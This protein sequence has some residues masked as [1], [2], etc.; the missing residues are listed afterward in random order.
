MKLLACFNRILLSVCL[1]FVSHANADDAQRGAPRVSY[2]DASHSTLLLDVA[3]KQYVVDV[4]AGSIRDA[5]TTASQTSAS[6]APSPGPSPAA[7]LFQQ[8]CASC[9][10]TDG[11]GTR[12]A[13]TPDFTSHS[14]QNGLSDQQIVSTIRNGKPGRMPAWSGKLSDAQITE[15][16]A[17]IR[18]FANAAPGSSSTAQQEAA[19]SGVY[20]PGDDLLVSLPTGRAVERH[21]LYVN[22]THRF[23]D[24][25]FTGPGKGAELLGLDSV[26]ISSFGLRYGVTDKL[27]VSVWRSPS[28]IER[29]IQIM[30]AYNLLDENHEA[31]LNVSVRFSVEGQ[32]NFQRSFTENIEAIFSRTILS[33]A[34]F[35]V[36]PTFSFNARRLEP[37]GLVSSQIP[38]FPGVNTFSIGFGGALDIRPTVALVAEIIPTLFNSGELGI[39]RPAYSFGIQK[40]LW[41]HAFT[42]ALTNSPGTTVSQRAGTRATY[43]GMPNADTPAGL[44]LGFDLMRQIH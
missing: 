37:G 22:F 20:Q 4:A 5:G 31:P 19:A 29:P 23:M 40:K 43:T 27:S 28:F 16:A 11:K 6:R 34:Q 39:H 38:D 13:G 41:R 35:Y 9:H 18:L 10:G 25:A 7:S 32:N 42:L 15:L 30:A 8:N 1:V 12:S 24:T 44:S 14:I 26:S 36:V 2:L 3:G 33:R 21:G 17:Y